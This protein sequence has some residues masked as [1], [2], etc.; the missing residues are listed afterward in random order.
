MLFLIDGSISANGKDA[1]FAAGKAFAAEIANELGDEVSANRIR[2]AAAVF[3]KKAS[4]RLTF[5]STTTGLNTARS[6]A[7]VCTPV[8]A[9]DLHVYRVVT[10]RTGEIYEKPK[11]CVCRHVVWYSISSASTEGKLSL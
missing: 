11:G 3:G 2:V 4:A 8:H 1:T 7:E 10:P 9:F 5:A 6:L